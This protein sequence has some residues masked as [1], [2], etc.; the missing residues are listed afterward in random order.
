MDNTQ[1]CKQLIITITIVFYIL[2]FFKIQNTRNS[3]SFSASS[4]KKTK[5]LSVH[6]GAYMYCPLLLRHD[7]YCPITLSC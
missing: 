7:T 3:E 1:F 2:G 4:E 5:H 6:D